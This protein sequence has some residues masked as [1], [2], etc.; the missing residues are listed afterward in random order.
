[1]P[2]QI[3][4]RDQHF[5]SDGKPKRILSLDGGGLRG[6]LSLGILGKIEG[7]LRERHGG[8]NDFRLCHY[9]DLIAGTST[10]AIIA[11]ALAQGWTVG[12]LTDKYFSL[13]RR[14]FERGLIRQILLRA[15]Y[16]E[17]SLVAEL[18]DVFGA[19]TTLGGPKLLTGLLIVIKRLD[20]GSPW[21]VSNNPHGRY[22]VAADNGRMGNGDYPLWQV[23]RASTA[24]PSYFEPETISITGG[25]NVSPVTGS[26]IDGGVSPFNNPALQALMYAVLE[27]YRVVWETGSDK[28]L[29]VSVGT[30]AAD[31]AVS[32]AKLTASHALRALKSVLQDCAV[33]QETMLQWM[34]ASPTARIIDRELG[35]LEGDLLSGAPVMSYL[36]YN[37]DLRPESVRRLDGTL[38]TMDTSALSAMDAPG[39][40]EVL[41]RLGRLAAA[42]DVRDTDFDAVFDLPPA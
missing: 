14:V 8:G 37:V 2:Y 35:G 7:L 28:L 34:S 36:R 4:T 31:P 13:G 23:V 11:A 41:H 30:G 16:D 38:A 17:Q 19:D 40:M 5:L 33:Q 24:A 29:L 9:F 32:K 10:G 27:G 20:S 15:K 39:N 3:L 21:P 6:I 26:F 1:M 18:K 42:Q 25:R 22:F 12:E